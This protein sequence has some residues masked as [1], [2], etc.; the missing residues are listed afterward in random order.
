MAPMQ[1]P[2]L[3][4]HNAA[5]Y[6]LDPSRPVAASVG[7]RAG[8]IAF[9]GDAADA[10]RLSGPRTRRYDA[11]GGVLLPGFHDAHLHLLGMAARLLSIDCT[12]AAVRSL[13]DL[14]QR[15][16]EAARQAPPGAW[17]RAWGYDDTAL[18]ERRHPTRH[19]LDAAAPRNPVRL[20]HRSGH[21]VVLNSLAL[22]AVDIRRHTPDP[23]G[24]A[25]DRDHHGD[26]TGLL[27][28]MGA[29]LAGRVPRLP[30]DDLERGVRD[31]GA[32]LLSRGV[33]SAQDASPD[34]DLSRLRLLRRMA[35]NGAI[36]PRLTV[37][38]GARHLGEFPAACAD[39]PP[40]PLAEA[41]NLPPLPLRE[42]PN[43]PPLP[44]REAPNLP[45]LPLG[46]APNLPPL[47]LGEAPNLPPL[48][49]GEGWGEGPRL[50]HAKIMLTASTGALS[51]ST[52]ELE[53]LVRA[54]VDRGYPVA[55]HCVEAHAVRAAARV[56]RRV[57]PPAGS[58][59]PHRIEHASELPPDALDAVR[60]SGAMV[61][62]NPGFVHFGGERYRRTVPPAQQPW[63]YRIGALHRAGVPLAFGSDAPVEMPEPLAE[64]AAAVTR[65]SS[66]G[67]LLGSTTEA[68]AAADAFRIAIRGGAHAAGAGEWLGAL[69]SGMAADLVLLDADP[70]RRPP[71]EWPRLRV[72]A[73][74]VAGRIAWEA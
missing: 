33:T 30:P 63:L 38:P 34:N 35:G 49:L 73:T 31:A 54:A 58:S 40:L 28:E 27:L 13:G 68:V 50:G 25:I 65:R 12:P 2:D 26:P 11:H 5:V 10:A 22:A 39:V 60:A 48:P 16:A 59:A 23:P 72:L 7:V 71:A 37:M 36:A 55:V 43:L 8:R 51:P 74:I 67:G 53:A 69:R 18:A 17:L 52:D 1:Q 24:G 20:T 44:L 62:T 64:L 41:P 4:I 66:E 9:V 15:I 46:E 14:T 47:P 3:V 21:A 57:P 45:P 6:T 42:A 70:F 19:D 56:L 61:V 29:Y 32:W